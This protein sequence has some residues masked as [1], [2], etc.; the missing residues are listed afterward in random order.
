MSTG[1]DLFMLMRRGAAILLLISLTTFQLACSG[2]REGSSGA[3]PAPHYRPGFNLFKPEQDIELGRQSAEQIKQQM[4]L[5][6]D[7]V[8]ANYIRKL[9]GRLAEKASGH[10][11]PYQFDVVA[12]KEINAF[13]LPGGFIFINAGTIMEAKNEGELAGVIAHEI[14]HVA[15]RHGTNQASKA[16]LARAGLGIL[17][18]IA[19]GASPDL[20]QVISVIGGVGANMAFLKF[21][22]AAETQADLEGA[23]IMAEAGYDPRDMAGFFE[24][25]KQKGGQRIPEFLSDHPDPGNRAAAIAEILPSLPMS[26]NPTRNTDEFEN[27]KA[28]LTGSSSSLSSSVELARSG[29]RDPNNNE[30]GTRPEPPSSSFTEFQAQ[31]GSFY[32]K[33]P[34]NWDV[35]SADETNIIFAP[36]GAYGRLDNSVVVTHGIFIGV[37]PAQSNNLEA[38]TAVVE[39]Q[40]KSN[41][42]FRVVGSTQQISLNGRACYATMVAGP[43]TITG[44]TEIDMIYTTATADGQLFY[45]IT[46][47]PQDELNSYQT[48]FD[49]IIASLRL[50]G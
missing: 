44:V 9:G 42:D 40:V 43:S 22:R 31:S 30:A 46:M 34:Q 14:T 28:R 19:G 5:L 20:G 23:R 48:V 35:L 39:Q 37:I 8:T 10:K 50:R 38:A 6:Q 4:R 24:T 7:E 13:A 18:A 47:S 26:S 49:Q 21:G 32:I 11:F 1:R 16:Y 17:T 12:T 27:V 41:P 3:K 36:K 45:L 29:P 15:L 2:G 33:Y 25:L